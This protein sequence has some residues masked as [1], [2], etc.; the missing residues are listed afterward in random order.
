[1]KEDI[2]NKSVSDIRLRSLQKC[3][4]KTDSLIFNRDN[5]IVH[6]KKTNSTSLFNNTNLGVNFS[7][8]KYGNLETYVDNSG[9]SVAVSANDIKGSN[10]E[11]KK[12][13]NNI[14]D[15]IFIDKRMHTNDRRGVRFGSVDCVN[16]NS[17]NIYSN[18]RKNVTFNTKIYDDQDYFYN[19]INPTVENTD[20]NNINASSLTTG[21]T[22]NDV[23]NLHIFKDKNPITDYLYNKNKDHFYNG[24]RIGFHVNFS[25]V[26]TSI[27]LRCNPYKLTKN[28]VDN[29]TKYELYEKNKPLTFNYGPSITSLPSNNKHLS[30]GVYANIFNAN[31]LTPDSAFIKNHSESNRSFNGNYDDGSFW[32]WHNDAHTNIINM[33]YDTYLENIMDSFD[34]AK[35]ITFIKKHSNNKLNNNFGIYSTKNVTN[36]HTNYAY[37]YNGADT[38]CNVLIKSID[39]NE[40]KH[41]QCG[42]YRTSY[43]PTHAGYDNYGNWYEYEGDWECWDC[44]YVTSDVYKLIFPFGVYVSN[45][46]NIS[47]D[48]QIIINKISE[49][50]N[51]SVS[52]LKK[53]NAINY[54]NIDEEN[55]NSDV[56]FTN[57]INV[58]DVTVDGHTYKI[59]PSISVMD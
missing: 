36:I 58:P 18:T 47:A 49:I 56:H 26:A 17:N 48:K 59:E 22:N 37:L 19:L 11:I 10:K 55:L 46:S 35:I 52:K 50:G 32:R 27:L 45:T 5:S 29:V 16:I 20:I 53:M 42:V 3:I 24:I 7:C 25:D 15:E 28:T 9:T 43:R 6:I 44:N 39:Y 40:T 2:L 34:Y 31:T 54:L 8:N 12:A 4:N 41:I 51:K 33:I 21:D 14:Y 38:K 23:G 13:C 1:M 30:Y 57:T